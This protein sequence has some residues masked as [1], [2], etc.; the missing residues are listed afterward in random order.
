MLQ[1]RYRNYEIV[2]FKAKNKANIHKTKFIYF[3]VEMRKLLFLNFLIEKYTNIY[4]RIDQFLKE[5]CKWCGDK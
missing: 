4:A 3:V 5:P 1:K 2:K